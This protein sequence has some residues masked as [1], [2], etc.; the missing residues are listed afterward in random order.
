M[1]LRTGIDLASVAE[2]S[3][4][5]EDEFTRDRV[6]TV[7]EQL[8][9]AD[10]PERRAGQWAAKEAVMKVLGVGVGTIDPREIEIINDEGEPPRVLLSGSALKMGQRLGITSMSIS[11]THELGAAVAVAVALA[12]ERA[13]NQ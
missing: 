3:S 8:S 1:K 5:A 10:Y 7:R 9:H 4:L 11:I 12:D 6:W 2:V 13:E